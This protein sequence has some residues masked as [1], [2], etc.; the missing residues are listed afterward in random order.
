MPELSRLENIV[1]D[2]CFKPV[3]QVCEK[4]KDT[5]IEV[6]VPK[7]CKHDKCLK[8][9]C[10]KNHLLLKEH[11]ESKA[12]KEKYAWQLQHFKDENGELKSKNEEQ[13]MIILRLEGDKRDLSVKCES[14]S[15]IIKQLEEQ[16]EKLKEGKIQCIREIQE[17]IVEKEIEKP[18]FI[19]LYNDIFLR[20]GNG[21][22]KKSI[23]FY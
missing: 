19:L 18:Y 22:N 21:D 10:R 17:K 20:G 15:I 12:D 3:Q 11:M 9:L 7:S 23:G 4:K 16:M 8:K 14:L 1:R 2:V 13:E 6:Q 5:K